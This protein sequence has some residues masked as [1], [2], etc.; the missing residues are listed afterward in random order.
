MIEQVLKIAKLVKVNTKVKV[1]EEHPA[2]NKFLDCALAAK[3][4]YVVSGD[5]HVLKVHSYT[6]TKMLSVS[7][8][9]EF[10]RQ[11]Y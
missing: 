1:I 5:K 2:D 8:F 10:L 3:A 6:Q 9:L 11:F 7:D 4:D